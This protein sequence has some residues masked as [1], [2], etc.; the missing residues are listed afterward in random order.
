MRVIV[1]QRPIEGGDYGLP[2]AVYCARCRE[3]L[4]THDEFDN[5]L[6]VFDDRHEC[7]DE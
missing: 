2:V 7:G 1:E 6:D 3:Y 5:I 4:N